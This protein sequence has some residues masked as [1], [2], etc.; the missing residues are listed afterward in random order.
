MMIVDML[1]GCFGKIKM[2][3]SIGKFDDTKILTD[4]DNNLDDKVTSK[5]A[6]V[7]PIVHGIL[8]CKDAPPPIS[9]L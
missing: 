1:D 2:I 9:N 6:L 4:T 3:I 8:C 7:L 5:F